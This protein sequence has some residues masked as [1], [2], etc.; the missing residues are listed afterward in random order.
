MYLLLLVAHS[1]LRWVVLFAGVAALGGAV[2]GVATRRAWLPADNLRGLLFAVSLDVQVLV[3]LV[4]Y[5]GFSPMAMPALGDMAGTM[6]DPVLRF[7]AVE[8]LIGAIAALALA[9]VGRARARRG[10][11][12]TARHKSTLVFTGLALA[13]LMLSIPWPGTAGGRALFRGF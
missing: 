2:G 8:H 3:G 9:H 1:G 7:Y 6:R 4:L 10:T 5:V 12:P 11:D 13:V